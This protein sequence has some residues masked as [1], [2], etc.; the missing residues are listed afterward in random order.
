ME[1]PIAE[2]KDVVRS[3]VEPDSLQV[4]AN[5]IDKWF[6]EDA[7]IEHPFLNQPHTAHGKD[8]IK[9]YY[10]CLRVF[11]SHTKTE[12]H[13]VMFNED[14]TKAFIELTQHTNP[15]IMGF[16]LGDCFRMH[17]RFLVIVDLRKGPHDR[18]FRI[19]R[20]EDNFP[21]DFSKAGYPP[22]PGLGFLSN[23][24]KGFNAIVGGTLGQIILAK[25]R[26]GS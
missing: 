1:N 11:T 25:G 8:M 14:S 22:I 7:Y 13:V 17:V 4:I 21:S 2:M 12:F 26:G 3:L 16:T 23:V 15:C 18:K 9:G 24:I 19:S 5:N 20:Q 10:T 6:T